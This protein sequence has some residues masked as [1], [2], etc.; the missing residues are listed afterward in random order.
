MGDFYLKIT[1]LVVILAA[2]L[3]L[4]FWWSWRRSR[5]DHAEH[6]EALTALATSLGGSV[7]G[8]EA[9][10]PR[11]A[12]LL[13]PFLNDTEGFINRFGTVRGPRFDVALDVQRG[14]WRVRV[15]EASMKKNVSNG[16]RTFYEHR[17][18]VETGPLPPMKISRRLHSD[19]LGRPIK[20]GNVLAQG[21]GPVRQAPVTVAQRQGEWL[22]TR[23][24]PPADHEFV[25]FADDPDAAVRTLTPQ[26]IEHLVGQA[27]SLP[28]LLT[29]EA[30]L[31]YAPMT[32]R[33]A[34]GSLR[35]TVD[36][37]LGLLDRL[38]GAR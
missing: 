31:L 7:A 38:P 30:G 10:A 16:T 5:K 23:L 8:P 29:F 14:P 36:A 33:I 35:T 32:G 4:A 37:M 18:E 22:P 13:P 34:P 1:L 20:P 6:V 24:P 26:A 15:T 25:V 27:G 21:G 9:A 28:Y 2:L 11:S 19:F 3:G 12:A 17:I